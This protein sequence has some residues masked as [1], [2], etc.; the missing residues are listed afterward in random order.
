[1]NTEQNILS[2]ITAFLKY[3]K[4]DFE[5]KRRET[6][7]EI[8]DRN[9][10]MHLSKFPQLSEEIENNYKYVYDK[11]VLPSMRSMQFAGKTIDINNVRIYN[12]CYLPIDDHRCFSEIMFLLLSGTGV[13]YSVQT[14]HIDKLPEIKI[15]LKTK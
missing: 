14:H 10:N 3:S 8:T 5:L 1:M 2:D 12:C 13:G 4:Y 6:W 7:S 9:K 15:P 11:K